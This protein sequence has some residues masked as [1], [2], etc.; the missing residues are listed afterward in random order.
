MRHLRRDAN[1]GQ[2]AHFASAAEG[3]LISQTVKVCVKT[4]ASIS[5]HGPSV[6]IRPTDSDD[7]ERQSQPG[8]ALGISGRRRSRDEVVKGR[9][10]VPSPNSQH[11]VIYRRMAVRM[12]ASGRADAPASIAVTRL[13]SYETSG[14][15]RVHALPAAVADPFS[16]VVRPRTYEPSLPFSAGSQTARAQQLQTQ[17]GAGRVARRR[18]WRFAGLGGLP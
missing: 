13:P 4:A 6:Y 17:F 7:A 15:S 10:A 1:G 3:K 16:G 5:G 14:G 2:V 18:S 9:A 8:D 11:G 12:P